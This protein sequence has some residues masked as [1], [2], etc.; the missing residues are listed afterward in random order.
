MSQPQ[1]AKPKRRER[2]GLRLILCLGLAT[3][4][5]FTAQAQGYHTAGTI[6]AIVVGVFGAIVASI[7][8]WRSML[9]QENRPSSRDQGE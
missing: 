8:G 6:A 5:L 1:P 3:A 2:W 9:R 4:G 7:L